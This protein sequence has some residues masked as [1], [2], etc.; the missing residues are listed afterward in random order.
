MKFKSLFSAK[1]LVSSQAECAQNYDGKKSFVKNKLPVFEAIVLLIAAIFFAVLAVKEYQPFSRLSS[2]SFENIAKKKIESNVDTLSAFLSLSDALMDSLESSLS[3]IPKD[4]KNELPRNLRTQIDESSVQGIFVYLEKKDIDARRLH[5]DSARLANRED[6]ISNPA[7][8]RFRRDAWQPDSGWSAYL[9]KGTRVFTKLDRRIVRTYYGWFKKADSLGLKN[10]WNGPV[11]DEGSKSRIIYRILPVE[12]G[13]QSGF[14]LIAHSTSRL[15]AYMQGIGIGR[16]GSPYILDTA[17]NFIVNATDE[18]RPLRELGKAYRDSIFTQLSE[19]VRS[20][21]PKEWYFHRNR[22]LGQY[23]NEFVF[24]IPN[25]PFYLGASVYSGDSQ[26]SGVYQGAMR[27]I[28]FRMLAYCAASVLLLLFSVKILFKPASGLVYFLIPVCLLALIIISIMIFYRYPSSGSGRMAASDYEEHSYSESD[29]AILK[30]NGV[31]FKWNPALVIDQK[32]VDFFV[33][34]YQNRSDSLYGSQAKILPTGVMIN[35]IRFTESNVVLA[36]GFVWQKFLI[37]SEQYPRHVSRKYLHNNYENKGVEFFG[38]QTQGS[39]GGIFKLVDSLQ[40]TMDG[41]KAILMRWAFV[42]ELEQVPSYGLYPFGIYNMP[43]TIK[44]KNKD[45]NTMLVPDMAAYSSMFP[46]D[47]PGIDNRLSI[48][49]W[50]VLQSSYSYR[51]SGRN[52][53]NLGNVNSQ[54]RAPDI[55]LNLFISTKFMDILVSKLLSVMVIVTLLFVL[56]FIR[57]KANILDTVLGCSGL[58]FALVL[59]HVN[60]RER[61]QST[62]VMYLEF[63]Y[64]TVYGFLLLTILSSVYLKK[65]EEADVVRLNSFMRNYFWSAFFGVMA[66][67]TMWRFY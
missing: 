65:I 22:L 9:P 51:F 8:Y 49:G 38:G 61:V 15:Y 57:D 42:V 23:C 64:L 29:R 40:T 1:N 34:R 3:L 35:S 50:N 39:Y 5:A 54:G 56:I 30:E 2:I 67:A 41:Y 17:G 20:G 55:R 16:Y 27:G 24:K 6:S 45:E 14:I 37:T 26:E 60:L 11:F 25:M 53:S 13:E 28:F 48:T 12:I 31:D 18:V 36:T 52:F 43:F 7:V 58:F 47:N 66:I 19:D 21:N 33:N 59:D 44:G 46:I 32:A 10:G 63:I 62:E 4:Y